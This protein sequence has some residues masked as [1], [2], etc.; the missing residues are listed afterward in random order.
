MKKLCSKCKIEKDLSEFY[1]D[2]SKPSGVGAYC[3][4]CSKLTRKKNNDATAIDLKWQ[5]RNRERV[6]AQSRERRRLQQKTYGVIN[7]RSASKRRALEVSTLGVLPTNYEEIIYATYGEICLK[8]DCIENIT[9]DHVIPLSK[10][11]LHCI[12]NMQPLCRSCNSSKGNR[13]H[14]DYREC[15]IILKGG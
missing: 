5:G 3:K 2:K 1:N 6:N 8:C 9:I 14:A 12:F 4:E 13:S 11:G 15:A 7:R 10:G